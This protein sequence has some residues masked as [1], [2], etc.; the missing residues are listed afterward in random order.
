[1][2]LPFFRSDRMAHALSVLYLHPHQEF[3]L[4]D[5]AR[6]IG[7]SPGALHADIDLLVSAGI[8]VDRIDG[9]SRKLRTNPDHPASGALAEL[10]LLTVAAESVIADHFAGLAGT[11]LLGIFGSWAARQAGQSEGFP[12]DIDVLVVGPV[13]RKAVYTA[14]DAA[15]ER[16]RI[17]V[18]PT[19]ISSERW[20][21]SQDGFVETLRSSPFISLAP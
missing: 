20:H 13:T 12:N 6:Q 7:V 5:L 1:M 10:L 8:V 19:I 17:P 2:L 3:S 18:N 9:R 11:E 14:A 16:L 15:S 21:D 4:S